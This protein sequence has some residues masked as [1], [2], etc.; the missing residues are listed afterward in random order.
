M[1]MNTVLIIDGVSIHTALMHQ[2]EF[3][4]TVA[5]NAPAV[6]CCRVSPT[7]KAVITEGVK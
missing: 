1:K 6:V 7:Q 3:F 2:R 5:S 4:F